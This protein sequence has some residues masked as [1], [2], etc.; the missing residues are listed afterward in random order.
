M[1]GVFLDNAIEYTLKH[2]LQQP[3][4]VKVSVWEDAIQISVGNQ[5]QRKESDDI[6]KMFKKG[7]STK[8]SNGRGFGLSNLLKIVEDYEGMI[9]ANSEYKPEYQCDYLTLTIEINPFTQVVE[10]RL[11]IKN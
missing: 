2:R 1:T 9:V 6:V 4:F 5:Y 10:S 3:I 7:Y 11:I 8:A